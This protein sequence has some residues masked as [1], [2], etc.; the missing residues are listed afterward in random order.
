VPQDLPRE[1]LTSD[2]Y[3]TDALRGV[4]VISFT[5]VPDDKVDLLDW[6]AA[7]DSLAR[8]FRYFGTGPLHDLSDSRLNR[9]G[10]GA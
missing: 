1:N 4:M 6:N 3:F 8:H 9:A 7:T 10:G 5:P 2:P